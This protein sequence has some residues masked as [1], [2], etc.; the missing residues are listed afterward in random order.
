MRNNRNDARRSARRSSRN[1]VKPTE[2]WAVLAAVGLILG[3]IAAYLIWNWRQK[4]APKID[5][6]VGVDT[7][8]S[9]ATAGRQQL[10]SI[11]DETVDTAIPQ[12]THISFWSY[13]VNAHKQAD[14]E[15]HKSRDLWKLEDDIIATHINTPGTYPSVVL[16]KMVTA[17]QL[18]GAAKRNCALM[19]LTDGED[20]DPRST[21]TFISEIAALPNVK[22]IWFEGVLTKNGFRSELERRFKPI[23][24][25]RLVI[26]SDNDAENGLAHFRDLIEKN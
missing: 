18:A 14:V 9:V 17:A 5:F 26:S 19:L 1:E 11:F 15:A 25:D 24:G 16:E 6:L 8:G 3:C 22:A 13:D 23:L 2:V 21:D 12:Q 20:A 7:S 4:P 10:F